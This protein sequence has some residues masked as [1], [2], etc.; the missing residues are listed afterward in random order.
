VHIVLVRNDVRSFADHE[1][2][3]AF[4]DGISR[5][6]DLLADRSESEARNV[7]LE[8]LAARP[9]E[10]VLEIGFG[11]GHA[12]A[13]LA[14]AVSGSGSVVGIDLS[15]GMVEI[16]RERLANVGVAGRVELVCAA[17]PPI[18]FP[19]ASFD[20]AFLSFTLESFADAAIA[21][22]LSELRRVL[23]AGG[24]LG[25]VA[26]STPAAGA[27]PHVLERA[28][29][30]LHRQFPHIVDCRP[31]DAAEALRAAGFGIVRR[32]GVEIWTLRVAALLARAE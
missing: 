24:R 26:L 7:G 14:E 6:Y 1:T 29:G 31:I 28:Y 19:D 30:W 12:L 15:P 11:T 18:S 17:V 2:T 10:S 23:R 21:R 16:A 13:R 3:R 9:G 8:L 32:A 25:L 27:T 20:A 4:Y 5:V 22:V